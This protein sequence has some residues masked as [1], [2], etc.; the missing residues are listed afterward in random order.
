MAKK[1][2][3]VE[4]RNVLNHL[5]SNYMTL[6]EARFLCIYLAKINPRKKEETR[7]VKFSL[8]DFVKIMEIQGN[9]SIEYIEKTTDKLLHKIVRVP[10]QNN[11]RSSFQLFK[12][13]TIDQ[14]KDS[15]EWFVEIDAHDESLPLMFDFKREFLTYELWNVLQLKSVNQV[16]MYEILKQ[17]EKIGERIISLEEL[18]ELLGIE[19]NEY[20]RFERFK[21]KVLNVCQKALKEYTD[22]QFEWEVF[23]RG[24]RGGKVLELRFIISKNDEYKDI[25]NLDMYL[26]NYAYQE[27]PC[28]EPI[29]KNPINTVSSPV[30]NSDVKEKVSKSDIEI[31]QNHKFW[32][33]AIEIANKNKNVKSPIPYAAKIVFSWLSKG[34]QTRNDLII[35]GEIQGQVTSYDMDDVCNQF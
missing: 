4:K 23:K 26:K 7:R 8:K 25:L 34:Y 18:K 19:Q 30:N 11:G 17:Y 2:M 22:I 16:R 28:S 10:T 21:E 13:C 35:A 6:Q 32:K 5:K 24:Q 27:L 20:P 9:I 33:Y 15:L 14:D 3:I 31:A 29:N 1:K 12:K